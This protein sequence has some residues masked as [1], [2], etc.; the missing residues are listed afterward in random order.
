ML[1]SWREEI[2]KARGLNRFRSLHSTLR[3]IW[4]DVFGRIHGLQGKR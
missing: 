1:D 4:H 3:F 2:D